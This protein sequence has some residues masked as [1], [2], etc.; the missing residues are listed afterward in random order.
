M[1]ILK[2][3][4]LPFGLSCCYTSQNLDS[5]SSLEFI[6]QMV[7]WGAKFVWYF[8]YMPVGNDAV[9]ELLPNPR[10]REFMYHRI[11]EIV[12][13]HPA[14]LE[15]V[16]SMQAFAFW[17][18]YRMLLRS[19]REQEFPAEAKE[20]RRTL[21]ESRRYLLGGQGLRQRI[22]FRFYLTCGRL[23]TWI[24]SRR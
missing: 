18:L 16:T 5:I 8:H 23:A 21:Q 24:D 7:A 9:P 13:E 3:K 1:A 12:K 4:H 6:D 2:R 20:L 19:G 22:M 11:R 17:N 14:M 15:S 10:Q